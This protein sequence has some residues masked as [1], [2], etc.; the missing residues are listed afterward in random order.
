[1]YVCVCTCVI[2]HELTRRPG[3][4]LPE[5]SRLANGPEFSHKYAR[6]LENYT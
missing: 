5:I 2:G 1:M 6:E 4:F 3:K